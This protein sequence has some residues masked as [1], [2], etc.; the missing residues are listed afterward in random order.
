MTPEHHS[1]V[2]ALKVLWAAPASALGLVLALPALLLGARIA[3]HS[4]VVEVTLRGGSGSTARRRRLPFH[5]ITFGHVVIAAGAEAQ[6]RLRSHERVHVAQYERLGPLFLLAYP[7]ESLFQLLRGRRPYID[8][9]FEREARRLAAA[10]D[11]TFNAAS[12]PP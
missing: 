2:R 11:A 10:S 5:A 1:L 7:A 4:G 6:R 9:R 3:R 12:E 8:N